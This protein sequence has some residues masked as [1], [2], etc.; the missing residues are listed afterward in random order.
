MKGNWEAFRPFKNF[1]VIDGNSPLVPWRLPQ[2]WTVVVV[3]GREG[4]VVV[5]AW[6]LRRGG[7]G[8]DWGGHCAPIVTDLISSVP[9]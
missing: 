3:R 2:L 4:L 8:R 1:P 6:L 9:Q 5:R 7:P